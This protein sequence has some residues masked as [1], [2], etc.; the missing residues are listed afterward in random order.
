M[1][2]VGYHSETEVPCSVPSSQDSV[3][4]AT[5]VVQTPIEH[6]NERGRGEGSTQEYVGNGLNLSLEKKNGNISVSSKNFVYFN[7]LMKNN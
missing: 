2:P 5:P 1:G 6:I 4:P 7:L 3:I